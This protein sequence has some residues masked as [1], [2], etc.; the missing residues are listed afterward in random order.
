MNIVC[1]IPARYNS[2]RFKG[3]PLAEINGKPMIWWVYKNAKKVTKFSKVIVAT[4][5]EKIYDVCKKLQI[6]VIMTSP[7]HKTPLN[8]IHE[9]SENIS[10]DYYMCLNGDEPLIS[11]EIIEQLIPNRIISQDIKVINAMTT[12][13][14]IPEVIDFTNLKIVTNKLGE[15]VYISR[16]P[17]PYPKGTLDFE[18]KKYVGIT[19]LNK[20]A[21][22]LYNETKRGVLESTE[23]NDLIRYLEN[24]HKVDMI[25]VKC[26]V[27]SVDTEK[28]LF[29]V[30]E[31]MK[32]R[33]DY[34]D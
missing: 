24:G 10:A 11:P 13:K 15:C 23:D 31:I 2:S 6:E 28:D 16:S 33:V 7:N 1:V 25:D 20:N 26:D 27:L 22:D 17:I 8:R 30:R 9:V 19:V 32:S 3:K 5:H 12:I 34:N 21:L 18:Y 4:D 29:T 14:N